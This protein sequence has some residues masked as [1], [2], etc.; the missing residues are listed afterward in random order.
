MGKPLTFEERQR[1]LN[2]T[3]DAGTQVLVI[4]GAGE[5]TEEPGFTQFIRPVLEYACRLGLGTILF[6]TAGHLTREQIEFFVSHNASLYISL[7]SLQPETYRFLTG[8][9][10]LER[11]ME[12]LQM[13]RFVYAGTITT[14]GETRVVRLGVNTCVCLPNLGN[15]ECIKEFA[16]NDMHYVANCPMRRGRFAKE[17]VWQM[18]V[19]DSYELSRQRAREMSE[20]G[21]PTSTSDGVCT[22]FSK[23]ISVDVDG[24][25]LVCCYAG[26]TA[27]SFGNI[28]QIATSED[29]LQHFRDKQMRCQQ[30]FDQHGR[31]NP[32][33]LR[34]KNWPLLVATLKNSPFNILPSA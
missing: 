32:C 13:L 33:P 3:K 6:T 26:E 15:L 20:T 11:V 9:G 30:F 16:G 10:N 27:G 29:L 31:D 23:G 14:I 24:E 1:V 17:K 21:G 8:C 25:L 22:Y 28:R 12:K 5:P 4:I 34:D 18:L 7:D 2:L 19:G